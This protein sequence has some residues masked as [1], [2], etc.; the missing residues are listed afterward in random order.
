MTP[1]QLLPGVVISRRNF[2]LQMVRLQGQ[3]GILVHT[4]GALG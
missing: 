4:K 3:L 1:L 2:S